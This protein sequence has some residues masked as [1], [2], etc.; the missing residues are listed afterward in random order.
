MIRRLLWLCLGTVLGAW[1]AFRLRRLARAVSPGGLATQATGLGR[2]VREFTGDVRVAMR[3]REE[4][5]RDALRLDA[6]A[7]IDKDLH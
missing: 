6:Q 7:D 3:S 4:E 5:L 2:T 1:S